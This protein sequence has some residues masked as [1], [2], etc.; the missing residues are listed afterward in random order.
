[1]PRARSVTAAT[2]SPI[3]G[4]KPCAAVH[5][6]RFVAPSSKAAVPRSASRITAT[7]TA[8]EQAA[9]QAALDAYVKRM[10]RD[11]KAY[12]R[13]HHDKAHRKAFVKKQQARLSALQAAAA[14]QVETPT[15]PAPPPP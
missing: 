1:M 3:P 10:A 14:C 12:F 7:C 9:N 5:V 8:D 6:G 2:P 13:R 15:P 4:S 11:R